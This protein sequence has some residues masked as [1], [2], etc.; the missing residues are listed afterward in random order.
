MADFIPDPSD[1]SPLSALNK[2][3][4]K[5]IDAAITAAAQAGP[6]QQGD[7]TGGYT[8]A[9]S[10]LSQLPL[11]PLFSDAQQA[12]LASQQ[13][14]KEHRIGHMNAMDPDKN[15]TAGDKAFL[16]AASHITGA[17]GMV[18]TKR[19][20]RRLQGAKVMSGDL[21]TAQDRLVVFTRW[22]VSNGHSTPW[23]VDVLEHRMYD[24]SKKGPNQVRLKAG[25][26][27]NDKITLRLLKT[28]AK[29][30][31]SQKKWSKKWNFTI[32]DEMMLVGNDGATHPM[33]IVARISRPCSVLE[34]LEVEKRF[35]KDWSVP[36]FQ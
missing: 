4:T 22:T 20:E 5:R 23:F 8:L 33:A 13:R 28:E 35:K 3:P 11:F 9:Y 18:A 10:H 14:L 30:L 26:S 32:C 21:K 25:F 36:I 12:I 19:W 34:V 29:G 2:L 16:S 1:S 15:L 31:K 6:T 24:P 17:S 7:Q 27:T